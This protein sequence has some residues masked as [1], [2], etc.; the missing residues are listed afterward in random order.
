MRPVAARSS[1]EIALTDS[2]LVRADNLELSG[3]P[4]IAPDAEQEEEEEEDDEAEAS[5]D[6][7]A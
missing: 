2:P 3:I 5:G 1:L 6:D 7:D 4:T